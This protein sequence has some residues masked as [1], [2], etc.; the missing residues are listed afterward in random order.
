VQAVEQVPAP[1]HT[2]GEHARTAPG[3]HVP[4]PSQRARARSEPAM[5]IGGMQ[6]V[7]ETY[8]RQAP[9]PSHA[10]S[11][12]HVVAPLSAHWPSGS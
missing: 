11:S 12:P 5:H 9:A 4:M 1:P 2:Y 3:T 10:P 6:L 8:L 7:P